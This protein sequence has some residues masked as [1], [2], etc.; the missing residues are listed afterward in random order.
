MYTGG[1][2]ETHS[3]YMPEWRLLVDAPEGTAEWLM[4]TGHSVEGL[5]LTHGHV[6]HVWDAA[7][8]QREHQCR[9]YYHP[10]TAPMIRDPHFFRRF[11]MP[12]DVDPVSPGLEVLEQPGW[13]VS[14]AVFRVLY[15]PGHCPGSLCFLDEQNGILFGGDVL[16]CGGV[17]R[18]DLPGGDRDLLLEGIRKKLM[19]LDDDVKV[20][21]GHGPSTTIGSERTQNPY[22]LGDFTG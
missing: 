22:V 10:E 5:L 8:I 12:W 21:P 17:G 3:Y 6:D 14:G 9:V 16:F 1:L 11:G 2:F 13:K 20:L 18:W 4:S 7:R 19:V 15:V